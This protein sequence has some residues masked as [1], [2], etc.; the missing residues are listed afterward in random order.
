M[1]REI[2]IKNTI[3]IFESQK[4]LQDF[5]LNV[6]NPMQETENLAVHHSKFIVIKDSWLR[7]LLI[8]FFG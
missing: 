4:D 1:I 7:K 3:F 2:E 6:M 8:Y 5:W